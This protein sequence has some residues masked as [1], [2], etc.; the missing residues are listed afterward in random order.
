MPCLH[1]P[2]WWV[3]EGRQNEL[4]AA[5]FTFTLKHSLTNYSFSLDCSCLMQSLILFLHHS[6]TWKISST[7]DFEAYDYAS[8][9]NATLGLHRHLLGCFLMQVIKNLAKVITQEA[10]C[11][12]FFFKKATL[13]V[14]IASFSTWG[15][16]LKANI[17]YHF[18]P[19]FLSSFL[20]S[21]L[22]SYRFFVLYLLKT[23]FYSFFPTKMARNSSVVSSLICSKA[24]NDHCFSCTDFMK[25]CPQPSQQLL[26]CLTD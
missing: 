26:V 21:L 7:R 16:S 23:P 10:Y 19:S 17:Y 2:R 24:E 4:P 22:P 12:F 6:W 9:C 14:F 25:K 5:R 18:L 13:K 11:L 8:V 15:T 1:E 20:P 3:A